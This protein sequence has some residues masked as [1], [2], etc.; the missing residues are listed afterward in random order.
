LSDR[1][2]RQGSYLYGVRFGTETRYVM[3]DID[4]GSP[5]H[6]SRDSLAL[7]RLTEA[8]EPL[9]L[10]DYVTIT[11]SYSNGLHVYFPLDHACLSWQIALV[12]STLLENH[13]FKANPGHLEIFPNPKS[14]VSEGDFSLFN[15][16]RL[17]LQI[18]SYLLDDDF[19]PVSHSEARFLDYWDHAQSRNELDDRLFSRILKQARKHLHQLSGKADKFLS[20]LNAEI[21]MGWTGKGQTNRLLGRIVMKTY[22]FHHIL[23]GSEPLT[24]DRLQAEC[25]KIARSLP[26]FTDWCGHQHELDDRIAEW[27]RCVEQSKY[28]AYGTKTD[29]KPIEPKTDRTELIRNK[30]KGAITDLLNKDSLTSGSTDRFKQLLTYGIGGASL[31]QH[32]DLWHPKFITE[33]YSKDQTSLLGA[34]LGNSG[35]VQVSDAPLEPTSSDRSTLTR[36]IDWITGS[37]LEFL[38]HTLE[39]LTTKISITSGGDDRPPSASPNNSPPGPTSTALTQSIPDPKSSP[40]LK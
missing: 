32:K 35:M 39:T 15:A 3:L 22:I 8:L 27:I 33:D 20:D 36:S 24:G 13:G 7:T 4:T 30:I 25:V 12:V 2:I 37:L 5:Y 16:H 23:T 6:P 34:D 14:Y 21:E 40:N 38:V 19:N 1:A 28:F 31:Y 18:G 9:G 26:G 11:S 10:T 29:P 17:P